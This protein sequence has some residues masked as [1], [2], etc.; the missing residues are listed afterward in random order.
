MWTPFDSFSDIFSEL[1]CKV[2]LGFY[3]L[4]WLI[5][6]HFL[7]VFFFA[8]SISTDVFY[9]RSLYL[10]LLAF[11]IASMTTMR[12]LFSLSHGSISLHILC[13]LRGGIYLPVSRTRR[14]SLSQ[15]ANT[16][17]ARERKRSKASNTCEGSFGL[18]SSIS[19]GS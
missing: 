12:A 17:L 14:S 19:V 11:S 3:S 13:R 18:F 10:L 1:S 8:F 5:F 15:L 16:L 7:L 6:K 4:L 2:F 9:P